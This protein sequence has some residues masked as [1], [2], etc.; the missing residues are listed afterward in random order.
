MPSTVHNRSVNK[1]Y[2]ENWRQNGS[3]YETAKPNVWCARDPSDG[4]KSRLL[5]VG[6]INQVVCHSL[7][8][9]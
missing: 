1:G 9:N 2:M 3:F 8:N 4:W 7:T 5:I 6:V